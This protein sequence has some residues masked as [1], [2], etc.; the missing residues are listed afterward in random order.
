MGDL[1]PIPS[2]QS[3]GLKSELKSQHL[4]NAAFLKALRKMDPD[5]CYQRFPDR[6]MRWLHRNFADPHKVARAF[7]VSDRAAQKWWDGVGGV[8]GGKVAYAVRTWPG[9]AEFLF[10]AE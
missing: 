7:G 10:A 2:E 5:D 8:N 6:W 9:A 3:F 4:A 1:K